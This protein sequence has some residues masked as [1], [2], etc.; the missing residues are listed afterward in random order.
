M[1][2]DRE[3]VV[4][5]VELVPPFK[6]R[7]VTVHVAPLEPSVCHSRPPYP[8]D[9]PRSFYLSGRK[10]FRFQQDLLMKKCRKHPISDFSFV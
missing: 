2:R 1:E 8:H 7:Q 6:S 10:G 4:V 3:E 9:A 5:V